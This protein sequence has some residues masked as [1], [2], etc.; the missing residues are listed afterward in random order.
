M[1]D[2]RDAEDS[3]LLAEG[4]LD[5][6]LAGYVAIVRARCIA[7]MRSEQVGEDVAQAVFLRLWRELKDGKHRDG[8]WPFRVIVHKVVDFTCAGWFEQGWREA[9][10]L[11]LDEPTPDATDAVDARL[12]LEAFVASLPPGDGAVAALAWL[13]GLGVEAIATRLGKQPNAIHQASFRNRA[14]LRA[15]LETGG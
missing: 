4:E 15:W 2:A 5:Q 8:A 1:R 13:D 7:K 10:W 9:E 11:E 3:R 6:L 14:A 12:D